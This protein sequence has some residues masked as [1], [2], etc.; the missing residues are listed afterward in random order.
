[1]ENITTMKVSEYI[2]EMKQT[3]KQFAYKMEHENN[4]LAYAVLVK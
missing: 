1:M 3:D 4:K 2:N